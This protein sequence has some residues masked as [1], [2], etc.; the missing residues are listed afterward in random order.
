MISGIFLCSGHFE[1]HFACVC[2][3]FFFPVR[4][5]NVNFKITQELRMNTSSNTATHNSK[6]FKL[7][8]WYSNIAADNS[9]QM[10]FP[11]IN[12]NLWKAPRLWRGN[13]P[14][15][16]RGRVSSDMTRALGCDARCFFC[17]AGV[18]LGAIDGPLVWHVLCMVTSTL[19]FCSFPSDLTRG[20]CLMRVHLCGAWWHR[21]AFL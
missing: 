10:M 14:R 15:I 16:W 4:D 12:F 2:H 13:F 7:T 5:L 20:V 21:V 18:A 6:S 17:V 9:P 3:W 8:L 1:G 11:T 19:R